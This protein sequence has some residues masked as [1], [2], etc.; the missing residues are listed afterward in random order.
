VN[1]RGLHNR[2]KSFIIIDAGM[3]R[4]PVKNPTDLVPLECA[5]DVELVFEDPLVGDNIHIA[6]VWN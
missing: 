1:H 6:R 4:D 2:A 5:V 3:L